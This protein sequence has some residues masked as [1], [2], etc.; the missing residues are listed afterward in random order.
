MSESVE[1]IEQKV[2]E[3]PAP[4]L[5]EKVIQAIKSVYDLKFQ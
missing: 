4:D 1:N 5:K 2:S 3:A